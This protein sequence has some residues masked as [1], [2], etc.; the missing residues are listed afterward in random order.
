MHSMT[1][2]E[3]TA[4]RQRR[5]AEAEAVAKAHWARLFK[6]LRAANPTQKISRARSALTVDG[7]EIE[8]SLDRERGGQSTIMHVSHGRYY[9]VIGRW[10]RHRPRP[11]AVE[12]KDG[13]NWA[14]V[15]QLVEAERLRIIREAESEATHAANQKAREAELKALFRRRPELRAVE[16]EVAIEHRK[17]PVALRGLTIEHVEMA[18]AVALAVRKAEDGAT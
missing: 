5:A 9:F 16:D 7:T 6:E 1:D 2:K 17:F 13:F 18:L 11:R 12:G 8:I 15:C 3:R 14:R 4:E 10:T